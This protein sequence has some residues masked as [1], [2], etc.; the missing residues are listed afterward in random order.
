MRLVPLPL[1]GLMLLDSPA[2]VDDRGLVRETY[3]E[4]VLRQAG[5]SVR[6]V[7]DN[8]SR[9]LPGVLRG[10]HYQRRRPQAKLVSV[11]AGEIYDV[12]VDLRRDQPG[13]GRWHAEVLSERNARSLYLPAGFAHGF[14]VV[15]GPADVLYRCSAPHDPD[16]QAGIRWDDPDL[17]IPWPLAGAPILSA[18]DRAL[19]RLRDLDHADLPDRS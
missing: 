6:F 5:V 12:A 17:A 2:H 19:P 18:R 10:L 8:H 4:D 11:L 7:Q 1:P 13:Y 3:R 15:A 16:D 9:S 14:Y